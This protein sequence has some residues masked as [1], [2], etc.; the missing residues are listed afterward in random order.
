[1]RIIDADKLKE[2]IN[3]D[4][5]DEP[6]TIYGVE[7]YIDKAPTVDLW[8]YPSKGEY[9]KDDEEVL[10]WYESDIKAVA[11]YFASDGIWFCDALFDVHR[12]PVCWQYITPPKEEA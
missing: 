1:M 8:H 7:Y 11:Q 3:R 6:L 9:P 2:R 12:P 5:V 4:D 10:C